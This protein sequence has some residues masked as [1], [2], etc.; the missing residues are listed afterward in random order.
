MSLILP[1]FLNALV[2]LSWKTQIKGSNE[3]I[4]VHRISRSSKNIMRRLLIYSLRRYLGN[5]TGYVQNQQRATIRFPRRCFWT[6][7]GLNEEFMHSCA[8]FFDLPSY[9]YRQK[10]LLGFKILHVVEIQVACINQNILPLKSAS[11]V[12]TLDVSTVMLT[13]GSVCFNS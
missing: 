2:K 13:I 3:V 5:K 1:K 8:I 12:T 11:F 10:I 7:M 9:Y 4:F 6:V